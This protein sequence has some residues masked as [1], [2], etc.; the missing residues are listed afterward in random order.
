MRSPLWGTGTPTRSCSRSGCAAIGR[1]RTPCTGSA[2]SLSVRTTRPSAPAQDRKSWPPYATPR[3]TSADSPGTPTSL[4]PNA[5]TAGHQAPPSTRS[6]QRDQQE[7]PQVNAIPDLAMPLPEH[8]CRDQ[9]T[10]PTATNP[11]DPR[12]GPTP[13]QRPPPGKTPAPQGPGMVGLPPQTPSRRAPPPLPTPSQ[14]P[15]SSPVV[16]VVAPPD[17]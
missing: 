16:L 1:S 15:S 4:P 11:A 12:R 8:P 10:D 6:P 3:S 9:R 13:V 2:T 5:T 14:D 7:S 17:R